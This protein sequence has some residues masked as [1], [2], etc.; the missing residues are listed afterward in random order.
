MRRS[1]RALAVP[2]ASAVLVC[3]LW[4]PGSAGAAAVELNRA[5]YLEG[6]RVGVTATGFTPRAEVTVRRNGTAIGTATADDIG[7]VQARFDAP[8]LPAGKRESNPVLELSDGTNRASTR[9]PI[10]RFH[11]SFSPSTGDPATMLVRFSVDGFGLLDAQP[12]VYLHYIGPDG[13]LRET[14]ELGRARGVCGHLRAPNL[15][16]LFPFRARP[17]TWTLQFDTRK[18]Y[19]RG[20]IDR[21]GFLFFSRRVRVVEDQRSLTTRP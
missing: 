21:P 19:R 2:A 16:R 6:A 18:A 10:T 9:L 11:A 13:V 15:R 3:A 1:R 12:D 14:V 7:A 4:A 5:C 17:G 20:R 8:Q